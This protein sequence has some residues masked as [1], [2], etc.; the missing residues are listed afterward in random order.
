MGVQVSD[1]GGCFPAEPTT[2]KF[3]GEGGR[4]MGIIEAIVDQLEVH[5]ARGS[6]RVRFAKRLLTA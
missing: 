2:K 4:G 5:P 6:T 1:C 3:H